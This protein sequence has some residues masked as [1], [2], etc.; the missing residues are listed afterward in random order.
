MV[1]E[2]LDVSGVISLVEVSFFKNPGILSV[3]IVVGQICYVPD[4]VL[5][6]L[7]KRWRNKQ[8]ST[9]HNSSRQL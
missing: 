4:H 6:I 3:H 7:I 8:Y 5:I 2:H 9:H 1:E